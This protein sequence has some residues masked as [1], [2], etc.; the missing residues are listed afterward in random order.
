[1]PDAAP[2]AT[3]A[4][5]RPP[6]DVKQLAQPNSFDLLRA[7]VLQGQS[8][9]WGDEGSASSD[10]SEPPPV[11]SAAPSQ[12]PPA[13][14]SQQPRPYQQRDAQFG[15]TRGPQGPMPPNLPASQPLQWRQ[16]QQ[17][18][19]QINLHE[20]QQHRQQQQQQQQQQNRQSQQHPRQQGVGATAGQ[21]GRPA[22]GPRDGPQP[23]KESEAL[24]N[25]VR[26]HEQAEA[27][28]SGHASGGDEAAGHAAAGAGAAA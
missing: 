14:P 17:Q 15:R 21:K 23:A 6:A 20:Q 26:V 1:M 10:T 9:R 19:H 7:E 18:H 25:G 5:E 3:S 28:A 12:P 11:P 2:P 4:R 8:G 22:R 13:A 16:D 24:A 27:R